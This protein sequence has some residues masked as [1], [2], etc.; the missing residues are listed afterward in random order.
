MV[1]TCKL[2]DQQKDLCN[3]HIIP[4]WAYDDMKQGHIVKIHGNS[5]KP[6][7]IQ[8]GVFD[9]KILCADCDNKILGSYDTYA[10][11]FFKKDFSSLVMQGTGPKGQSFQYI[12]LKDDLS[13]LRLFIISVFWR[14]SIT[15]RSE[16]KHVVSSAESQMAKQAI[17]SGNANNDFHVC[18]S[19]YEPS[20]Q[21]KDLEKNVYVFVPKKTDGNIVGYSFAMAGF[22]IG[23]YF[24]NSFPPRAT[25]GKEGIFIPVINF[26]Q[27]TRAQH[28]KEV[29]RTQ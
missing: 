8:T 5:G 21:A 25:L 9:K 4:D 6:Q 19:F 24:Q 2:C 13:Q 17:I 7:K 10:A 11:T 16:F 29:M 22:E 1:P 23:I 12:D 14:A 15:T 20:T 28:L 26:D 18:M 27:S 3:A